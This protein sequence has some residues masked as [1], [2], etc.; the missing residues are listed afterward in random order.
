MR[1]NSKFKPIG[2][3][4]ASCCFDDLSAWHCF[5]IFSTFLLF[6][7]QENLEKIYAPFR[8]YAPLLV[9]GFPLFWS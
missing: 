2:C 6:E 4:S 1:V 5:A 8:E 9:L 3:D 7:I